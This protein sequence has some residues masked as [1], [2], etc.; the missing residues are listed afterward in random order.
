MTGVLDSG[1]SGGTWDGTLVMDGAEVS[2]Q[3]DG[4]ARQ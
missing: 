2:G 1:T 4:G 3:W